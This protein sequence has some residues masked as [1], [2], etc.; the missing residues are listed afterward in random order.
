[1]PTG[2]KQLRAYQLACSLA[3]EIHPCV[4]TWPKIHQLSIGTQLLRSSHSIGA[5]IAEATGRWYYADQRRL[6]YV[7]RGS[8][9]ETEYWI[10]AACGLHLLPPEIKQHIP[11]LT[12]TLN[13]LIKKRERRGRA[14]IPNS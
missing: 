11:E 12:R 1:M 4:V 14:L 10:D 6:L 2:Y 8:L 13:G 7:A 5:N 3:S 9:Q